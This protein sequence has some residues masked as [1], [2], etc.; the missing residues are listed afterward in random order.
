MKRVLLSLTFLFL[1]TALLCGPGQLIASN[2]PETLLKQ[3]TSKTGFIE[4]KG[5]IINQNNKPNPAVLYLLNTPGMN[6]QLR[7]SGWSYDVYKVESSDTMPFA[8]RHSP[9]ASFDEDKTNS[10]QRTANNEQRNA[11]SERRTAI[12]FT[13]S[14]LISLM[15]TLIPPLKLLLL[16][17]A[18]W[19]IIPPE[20][21]LKELPVSG[22]LPQSPIKIFIQGSI[23]SLSMM[24]DFLNTISSFS[25]EQISM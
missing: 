2:K 14:T 3:Q 7:A 17:L 1:I 16:H 25:R 12:V 19:I 11:N 6:V 5:Q 8:F 13:A 4:N 22:H 15:P 9:F 21:L 10:K 20:H 24:T 18:I 23:F